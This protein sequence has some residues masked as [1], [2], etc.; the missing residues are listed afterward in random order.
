MRSLGERAVLVPMDGFHLADPELRRLGRAQRK[1][2]PDTS[3][4]PAT[5]TCCGGSSS[6]DDD[7][8]LRPGLP[9]RARAG[10]GGRAAGVPDDPAGRHRG[11][12]PA[13]RRALRTRARPARRPAG[14]SRSSRRCAASG[15]SPG[16]SVPAGHRSRP[17]T[18]SRRPTSRTPGWSR[19]PA[20]APTWWS[21]SPDPAP[22]RPPPR[23]PARRARRP[24]RPRR[25]RARRRPRRGAGDCHRAHSA[26]TSPA[27]R[28]SSGRC[29]C[30]QLLG[31]GLGGVHGHVH[32]GPHR[33]R[34][35]PAPGRRP[36]GR[37]ARA[38]R[39]PAPSRAHAPR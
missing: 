27:V 5:C 39:R 31:R 8:V 3:T 25:S 12:L 37:R 2:A 30:E 20:G 24:V 15:W 14:T 36:S 38:P 34:R 6:D 11:Q 23:R 16:T 22:A 7:E 1:G 21:G 35:R 17:P 13:A 9:A 18:G 32:R 19:A 26:L 29:S 10:R 33:A 4:Q 28:S